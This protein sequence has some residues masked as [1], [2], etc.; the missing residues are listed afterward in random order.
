L[1][2]SLLLTKSI[3]TA[4]VLQFSSKLILSLSAKFSNK[5]AILNHRSET[6]HDNTGRIIENQAPF[7]VYFTMPV[8]HYTAGET[9]NDVA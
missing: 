6:S 1:L 2:H 7:F 4:D 5:T 9:G 3:Y 8:T